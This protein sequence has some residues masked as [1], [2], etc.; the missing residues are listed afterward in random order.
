[1][2]QEPEDLAVNGSAAI[3]GTHAKSG[4]LHHTGEE[5]FTLLEVVITIIVIGIISLIAIPR[6]YDQYARLK[7]IAAARQVAADI[8][9]AQTVAMAEHDS[10][11]V[12]FDDT[13]NV[14]RVYS[15]PTTASRTLM[16]HPLEGGTYIRYLDRGKFKNVT[17]S[18]LSI[19]VDKAIGFDWFG[20]TSN[21]G[22]IVLNNW[23]TIDVEKETG[24]VEI[25][26]L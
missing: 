7:I 11:W 9:Y 24:L 15:G 3:P 14:Y 12:E 5:G 16:A 20:N 26:G 19:G 1:M 18:S 23:I 17:I 4:L 6:I 13:Q 22:Q 8:R 2:V 25:I 10:S 21:S